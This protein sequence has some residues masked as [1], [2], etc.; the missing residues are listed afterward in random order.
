MGGKQVHNTNATHHNTTAIGKTQQVNDGVKHFHDG[1]E[2]D[3]L[4]SVCLPKNMSRD[5]YTSRSLFPP[6]ETLATTTKNGHEHQFISFRVLF[7][8][9]EASRSARAALAC[10]AGFSKHPLHI[11]TPPPPSRP[12]PQNASQAHPFVVVF[13]HPGYMHWRFD[14]M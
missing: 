12:T 14:L 11:K 9:F 4:R 1:R 3:A 7:P 8:N 13:L 6:P 10:L 5:P 2:D